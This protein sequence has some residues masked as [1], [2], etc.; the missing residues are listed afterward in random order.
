MHLNIPLIR[1]SKGSLTNQ[2][3]A[4][5]FCIPP[6]VDINGSSQ[7]LSVLVMALE[8]HKR[9]FYCGFGFTLG[10]ASRTMPCPVVFLFTVL[11]S[12]GEPSCC[13]EGH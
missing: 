13:Q 11:L 9:D 5:F 12:L 7:T 4:H 1:N 6:F 2:T 3:N 10:C 8:N